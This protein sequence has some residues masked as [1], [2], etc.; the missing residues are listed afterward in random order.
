[1][2]VGTGLSAGAITTG[3]GC[4]ATTIGLGTAGAT[5]AT[6]TG[7]PPVRLPVVSCEAVPVTSMKPALVATPHD[8]RSERRE[9]SIEPEPLRSVRFIR[10]LRTGSVIAQRWPPRSVT[11]ESD[12]RLPSST[13]R[14]PR[15]LVTWIERSPREPARISAR[16]C[17]TRDSVVVI[18]D[19]TDTVVF[20]VTEKV[21]AKSPGPRCCAAAGVAT[22]SKTPAKEPVVSRARVIIPRMVLPDRAEIKP[23]FLLMVR[24][25]LMQRGMDEGRPTNVVLVRHAR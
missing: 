21:P 8:M 3:P 10:R 4:G 12:D 14:S 5:G 16:S 20:E 11:D 19:V 1:M 6:A 13:Q 17:V 25:S 24:S 15:S 23:R 9:P 2:V 18:G 7:P 22:R